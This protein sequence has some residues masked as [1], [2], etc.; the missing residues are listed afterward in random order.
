MEA[1]LTG[2]ISGTFSVFRNL[3][4]TQPMHALKYSVPAILYMI[5]NNLIFYSL[6]KL[7]MAV[8]QVTYQLKILTAAIL[9]VM[10]LGKEVSGVQWV[11]L[12]GLVIGVVVIQLPEEIVTPKAID[13]ANGPPDDSSIFDI[14]ALFGLGAVLL[15]CFFSGCA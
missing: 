14:D 6:E 12:I 1:L 11:A 8:Q 13:I 15:A 5:Q 3:F 2:S 4:L 7:S 9:S 10:I